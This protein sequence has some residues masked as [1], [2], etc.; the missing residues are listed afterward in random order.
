MPSP[1]AARRP[2]PLLPIPAPRQQA[3]QR[4]EFTGF[5]HF[6][7]NTF[8]DREWGLGDESPGLFNPTALDVRQWAR[9]ARDAGMKGLILTCKHH[10]GFCLWPSRHTEHSVKNAPWKDGKGDLVRECSDACREFGLKF[11]V[12]LSPWDRNHVDYG[13]P[14]YI[15]YYRA[16]LRELLTQ[17][18]PVFEVW[19]D[20]ANGGDGYYGGAR[21]RRTIDKATY[22][23]WP[24][25]IRLV[26]ELQPDAVMFSDAGPDIR[27]VG[28]ESGI[29]AETNWCT[30]NAGQRYPGY[31][32]EG[33]N[34]HLDLGVGHEG[35]THWMPAEVDVSIRPGW[36]WHEHEN[37]Q[38]RTAANLVDLYF[39]SIGRGGTLLLNLPPDR[40]G[41]IH[42]NDVEQL[43]AFRSALDR[44][45][46]NQVKATSAV[47]TSSMNPE[48]ACGAA[49]ATDGDPDTFWMADALQAAVEI[50]FEKPA[51]CNLAVLQEP[52]QMGQR[53]RAWT[54]EARCQGVWRPVATGTTVGYKR[55]VP[56][57]TVEAEALRMRVTDARACPA[58]ATFAAYVAPRIAR[59]PVLGRN[60][61]G[62]VT[63]D[64]GPETRVRYSVD[65]T[66]PDARAPQ[67][68]QPF[69]LPR[70]GLVRASVLAA[71][72]PACLPL[73]R[74][75]TERRFGIPKTRWQV[76][77]ASS[78]AL[79]WKHLA[80]NA[81]DDVP[82][83]FW[84]SDP[85]RPGHPHELVVDLGETVAIAAFGYLPRQD[86]RIDALVD[87]CA[88]HVSADGVTW[89]AAVA[90]AVFA[91]LAANPIQ[92]IVPLPTP[93]SARYVKF[94]SLAAVNQHPHAAV[95]ELD[96]F[97]DAT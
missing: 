68:T 55:A 39:Q 71:D 8:T 12:Y 34:P 92:Q 5:I 15:D 35:G 20:G 6:T 70:G 76:R 93:R 53:I 60:R 44:L 7:I 48:T 62:L 77:A 33:Y 80:A 52:I 43:L 63:I 66:E 19:F 72:N 30:L 83:T 97:T 87:R 11:G 13:R 21:E 67:F 37:G 46:A 85:D 47:A 29:A 3:W 79:S 84:H 95:A 57:P 75:T 17:Y 9:T 14:A 73:G 78:E 41:L 26:R 56:F 2:E 65:G 40:R 28:N 42:E 18:G 86:G 31:S 69:A 45:F 49:R 81:I 61:D 50:Q 64:A 74:Q 51:A 59:Q 82:E 90:S 10:D 94:V 1:S 32:P 54:L 27:W 91:N 25:T 89:Q 58:L 16:Q 38:V 23:D 88:F 96:V 22:Y 4:L 24:E 36:F